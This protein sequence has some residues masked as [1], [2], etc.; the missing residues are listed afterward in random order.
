LRPFDQRFGFTRGLAERV[1]D[2]REDERVRHPALSLLRQ[3]LY[4][5][6]AG[7]EHTNDADRLRHDPVFQTLADQPLGE[8]LGSQPTR[9]RWENSPSPRDLLKLQDALLDWFVKICREPVRK[10]G[11]ILLDI[12]ST[13]DPTYGQQQFSFFNG[14]YDQHRYHPLLIFE[15]RSGC[16][17]AARLRAGAVP[18]HARIIPLLLRIVPRRQKEFPKVHIKL[19]A[20]TGFA[21]PLLYEF[22]EFFGIQ[23]VCLL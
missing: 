12:D 23:E 2:S 3:R 1:L 8:P 20:D 16:L 10:R 6:I 21:L 19:R 4:Q 11:E 14:G 18:S 9:S 13:D 15:R 5:I 17:L 7:Y 22:C